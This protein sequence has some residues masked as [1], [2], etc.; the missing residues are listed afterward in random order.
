MPGCLFRRATGLLCPGC[1]GTRAISALFAGR[2]DV[3]LY[4]NPLVALG[5]ALAVAWTVW[6]VARSF[7]RPYAPPRFG[8]APWTGWVL[9]ACV[10]L[11]FVVR[12]LPGFA[13][14]AM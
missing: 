2:L 11:F 5:A 14:A 4:L 13:F 1:G 8:V 7:R 12:N 3:A 10:A 6:L 9:G